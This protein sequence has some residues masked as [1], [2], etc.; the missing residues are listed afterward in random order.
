MNTSQIGQLIVLAALWGASFLFMRIS[1]E[2]FGP[3]YL[4]EVRESI[5]ALCLLLLL[6]VIFE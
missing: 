3:Q 5:A 6:F 2:S 1:D 4:M